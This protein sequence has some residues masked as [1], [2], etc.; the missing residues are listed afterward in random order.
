MTIRFG[1]QMLRHEYMLPE[2]EPA[3][4]HIANL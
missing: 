3:G 1:W 4:W 2:I